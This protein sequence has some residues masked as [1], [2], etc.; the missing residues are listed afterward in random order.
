MVEMP[1]YMIRYA[2]FDAGVGYI[3]I[4]NMVPADDVAL[5]TLKVVVASRS[6]TYRPPTMFG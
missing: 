4:F 2:Y 6:N 1:G 5:D 3:P